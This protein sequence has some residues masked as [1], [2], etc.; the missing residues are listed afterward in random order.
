LSLL[1]P[2]IFLSTLFLNTLCQ[3]FSLN[4]T[5]Q[6]S[7]PYRY[8]YSS[9]YLYLFRQQTGRQNILHQW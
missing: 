1:G 4:V 6:A 9:I 3:C 2:N 5:D 7:H 8:N